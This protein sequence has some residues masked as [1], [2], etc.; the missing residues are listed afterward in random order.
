MVQFESGNALAIGP[1]SWFRQL[2]ELS[3]IQKRLQDVLLHIL[4]A[5]SDTLEFF[6]QGN[7][8]FPLPY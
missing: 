5:L 7:Q 2:S 1:Q 8:I 6:S 3:S 4:I